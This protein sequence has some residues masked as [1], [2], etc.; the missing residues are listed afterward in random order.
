MDSLLRREPVRAKA[1]VS[2]HLDELAIA[3]LPSRRGE[4]RA[5][6]TVRLKTD[7]LLGDQ[8]AA[9]YACQLVVGAGFEPATFGL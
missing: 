8:E 2:K 6:I 5:E 1:E 7:A 9:V 3:P 4:K